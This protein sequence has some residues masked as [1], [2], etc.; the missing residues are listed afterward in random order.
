[1]ISAPT[2]PFTGG[3]AAASAAA[4]GVLPLAVGPSMVIICFTTFTTF[5]LLCK[6][7]KFPAHL[8][9]FE[10]FIF[11]PSPNRQDISQYPLQKKTTFAAIHSH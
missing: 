4:K 3:S 11:L 2:P 10:R 1:M 7:T 6:G 8:Q 9:Y 5:N